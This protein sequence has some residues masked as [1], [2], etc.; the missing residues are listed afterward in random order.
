[1]KAHRSR[2]WAWAFGAACVAVFVARPAGATGCPDINIQLS[3]VVD[4]YTG[5]GDTSANRDP[6]RG[7]NLEPAWI[8]AQDCQKDVR[9]RF[10]L[11]M[12]GLPCKDTIQVWAGTTDCTQVSARQAGSTATRC[13][14]VTP[15]GA[16][17]VSSTSTADIRAEDI[18]AFMGSTDPPTKYAPRGA[19]ACAAIPTAEC[20]QGLTLYFMAMGADGLTVDGTSAAYAFGVEQTPPPTGTCGVGPID[21]DA[22]ANASGSAPGCST[23]RDESGDGMALVGVT[24]AALVVAGRKRR[25]R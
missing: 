14:P 5:T 4:R 19:N 11:N 13:W 15:D 24:V 17:E 8:D 25:K 1:M 10:T 12:T 6:L 3:P 7:P 22:G 21:G 20:G 9:L 16:F 18:V 23:A 2:P